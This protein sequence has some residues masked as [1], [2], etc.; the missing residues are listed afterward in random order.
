MYLLYPL[1]FTLVLSYSW[2]SP[3]QHNHRQK[4]NSNPAKDLDTI[5]V[6]TLSSSLGEYYE[7]ITD[8]V[9]I[10]FSRQLISDPANTHISRSLEQQVHFLHSNLIASIQPLVDSNLP[11]VISPP[12]KKEHA[13]KRSLGTDDDDDDDDE[14]DEEDDDDDESAHHQKKKKE[15]I[16][17]WSIPLKK[18]LQVLNRRISTQ[19][20]KIIHANQTAYTMMLQAHISR[21]H[22]VA[23]SRSQPHPWEWLA[24][25]LMTIE[26]TLNT[27]FNK[28]I[29][30]VVQCIMED[31]LI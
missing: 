27:E 23:L 18:D 5:D 8:Q 2:A 28:R 31:F 7:E 21:P 16:P 9:M 14:E 22:Q 3:I 17:I 13:K 10:S 19:L 15:P 25:K 29:Q 11:W 24:K 4:G 26:T 1:V 30:D 6:A 12:K 20:G